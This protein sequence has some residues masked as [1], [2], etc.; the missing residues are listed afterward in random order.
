MNRFRTMGTF[1]CGILVGASIIGSASAYVAEI[2]AQ[3]STQAI[4][5]DGVETPMTAYVING[6][7]YVKLRDVGEAVDFAVTYD[8]TTNS[9]Q[10]GSD[11]PHIAEDDVQPPTETKLK[12][13]ADMVT[14][15]YVIHDEIKDVYRVRVD[16]ETHAG[17]LSTGEEATE[18]NI[19]TMLDDFALL[20]PDGTSWGADY[21]DGDLYWYSSDPTATIGGTYGC[22]GYAFALRDTL[23]GNESEPINTH[24]D[25]TKV[26]IGDVVYLNNDT[27]GRGHW[28]VV[29]GRGQSFTG[30]EIIYA[31]SGNS[32]EKVS[33]DG[34]Y[35]LEAT[36]LDYPDS[37]IYCYY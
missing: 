24:H 20:Y 2:L 5:V 7:N 14:T 9:V 29:S 22:D 17:E 36:L 37:T 12:T 32:S 33:L 19:T 27:T 4:Y 25:L 26:R 21:N 8:P 23:Y 31:M 30:A 34:P 11:V 13:V 10:I 6:S 15:S 18:E 3:P 28:V 16:N 35:Y 1:S